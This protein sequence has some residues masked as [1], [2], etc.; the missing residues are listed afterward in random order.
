MCGKYIGVIDSGVGGLSVLSE[1]V[2]LMPNE[3]YLY[4]GDNDNAPYGE[5]CKR[6]LLSLTIENVTYLKTFGIKALVLACNTL[7]TNLLREI[8]EF[9]ELPVF[10]VFPPF[11][12]IG[13]GERALLMGTPLTIKNYISTFGKIPNLELLPLPT[14][15]L[16]IENGLDNPNIESQITAI[17]GSFE[18]IIL[19]C[20]HYFFIKNKIFN[21]LKP[22]NFS[23]GNVFC[24]QN[25]KK[26]LQSSKT[27]EKTK[28]NQILFIG[29]NKE[30]NRQFWGN[31][32][33]LLL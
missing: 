21:H 12:P 33:R 17:K 28:Q 5:K 1:L 4:F 29:K 8:T 30:K 9:S 13:K 16:D 31:Y 10:A 20:T 11:L 22:P 7:S 23:S 14:L 27:L 24:A 6:E 3:S 18:T 26:Y 32:G 19:G 15:A 2:K 25:V